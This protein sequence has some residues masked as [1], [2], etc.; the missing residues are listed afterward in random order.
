MKQYFLGLITRCKDEFFIKEFCDY[1]ISQGVNKIYVIDDDSDDKSI[2]NNIT[3]KHVEIVYE[4][5]VFKTFNRKS[6]DQMHTVNKL[7]KTIRNKF[8]WLISVDVDEFITTKRHKNNTI[9][10]ELKT[11]FKNI[12]CVCVPWVM[13]SSNGR[14]KN[15]KRI[16][17]ENTYRWNHDLKH[18]KVEKK[19]GKFRCLYNRIQ[20]KCIFKTNKFDTIMV[21]YPLSSNNRKRLGVDSKKTQYIK[22][23]WKK[24]RKYDYAEIKDETLK[25]KIKGIK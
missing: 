3:N 20:I 17:L 16:L 24:L 13:M 23:K 25:N 11:T 21:H 19:Y 14:K 7:Y 12:D 6:W 5:N 18:K 4:T 10:R 8:E 2:Y 1:Y 9:K 22:Y 15:P